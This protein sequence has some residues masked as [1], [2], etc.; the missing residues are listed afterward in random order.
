MTRMWVFPQRV[1]FLLKDIL[2]EKYDLRRMAVG[3]REPTH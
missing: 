2:K 1:L 3:M